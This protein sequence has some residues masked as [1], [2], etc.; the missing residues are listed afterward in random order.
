[1]P[2]PPQD[3]S[4]GNHGNGG[5]DPV[6][7][8]C[9]LDPKLTHEDLPFFIPDIQGTW[10]SACGRNRGVFVIDPP[11]GHTYDCGKMPSD[12]G[13]ESA[14]DITDLDKTQPATALKAYGKF[15]EAVYNT[16]I[17][18]TA[19]A[20]D[21]DALTVLTCGREEPWKT[22]P[23]Y[24]QI[25]APIRS[26]NIGG[27]FVLER[28]IVP[29]FTEWGDD[30]G[31]HDQ[32][33]YSEK[34]GDLGTCD[35]LKDH[36]KNWYTPQDFK[37][38]KDVGLNS[39]R[40]PV[41]WWFFAA[42]TAM[43]PYPYIIPDEDLYDEHHPITDVI[44]WAREAGL[45]VIL[46]LHGAPGSQNG[47]DNSGLTSPD[48]NDLVWGEGWMYS[49][50][51]LG[52]TVRI[53]AAM[54]EY[55][56]HI[57]DSY[58][59]DN[60][61]A[62]ELLNEPWAHLDLGR[63]RDFYV[64]GITAVRLVRPLM[65]IIIHD[66][67]RGPMW[68]TLLKDFP[69]KNV[70]MDT[71]IYHGFNPAD[72]SSDT[73]VGDRMKAYVHERMACSYTAMLRYQTCAVLPV[74]VGEWSLAIDN[75]MPW[76]DSKFA[77]YGQCDNLKEREGNSWWTEH[78]QSFAMRQIAM[79]ER[80]M[81]WSFWTWKLEDQL[82]ETEPAAKYW[83]FSLAVENG[84]IDTS[85]SPDA[86]MHPPAANYMDPDDH[87]GGGDADLAATGGSAAAAA[88]EGPSAEEEEQAAAAA[89][90]ANTPDAE[91]ESSAKLSA[92]PNEGSEATSSGVMI[93]MVLLGAMA[94]AL[95]TF[96]FGRAK[97]R[98]NNSAAAGAATNGGVAGGAGGGWRPA[99]FSSGYDTIG[100]QSVP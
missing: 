15:V 88:I 42:K 94:G 76:L 43:S 69:Y 22:A 89:G 27:L 10:G 26:V 45:Y 9:E 100:Q 29:T 66:S 67:F 55:I 36:W 6:N 62:L 24:H 33:S 72:L 77:D 74:M 97:A 52:N 20:C 38:M 51:N 81:G 50:E 84:F 30:S 90:L 11:D 1:Y 91:A 53:L 96:L 64:S 95:T 86:C 82:E 41:G 25:K 28:W 98:T 31:I 16:T 63:V 57:E 79:Y 75:C 21:F 3:Q 93:F 87:S 99:V 7:F 46:D 4:P 32:H 73:A 65:P 56:N 5:L 2:P 78:T 14:G 40:L 17:G 71:H 70:V 19:S 48:P 61:M 49:P 39:V 85:Y 68:A 13:V 35:E 8:R 54:A 59:L 80:E 34:C 23:W 44:R 12:W 92:G 60:I 58:S 83:S 47:L 18:K 37:D